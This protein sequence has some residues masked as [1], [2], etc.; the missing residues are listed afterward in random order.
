MLNGEFVVVKSL[1][2]ATKRESA[3]SETNPLIHVR[4][5]AVQSFG[6][7]V[8]AKAT[9]KDN[10]IQPPCLKVGWDKSGRMPIHR[11][12]FRGFLKFMP[13]VNRIRPLFADVHV[14]VLFF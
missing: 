6:K 2:I 1:R 14:V 13:P 8:M 10:R 3:R 7:E 11:Q 9:A 4:S 5:R 12:P